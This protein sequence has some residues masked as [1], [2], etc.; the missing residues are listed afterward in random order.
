MQ[1]PPAGSESGWIGDFEQEGAPEA[2][3]GAGWF[4]STDQLAGGKSSAKMEVVAGGAEGSK[5]ALRLTGE[6][7]QGFAFPWSGVMF[8]P[9]PRPMAPVNLAARKAIQFWA[10]GDGQTYQVMIF[11]QRLGYR[12]ATQTFVAGPDWKQ[13]TLPFASFD[14]IDGSD[15]TAIV[16]S[17]GPK[18][19]GFE[20]E[21]DNI[22]MQ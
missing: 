18:T 2:R 1:P 4:V 3:F 9:G 8:S 11:S 5:H 10:K 7:A 16:W 13:F 21:L 20:F 14:G 6:V 19:G 12:P 15:I 17:G 22:R